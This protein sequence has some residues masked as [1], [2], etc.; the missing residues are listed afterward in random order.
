M[1]LV[2][3]WMVGW[4]WN[5][6][7]A[8]MR[9]M[10]ERGGGGDGVLFYKRTAAHRG[11]ETGGAVASGLAWAPAVSGRCGKADSAPRE[12]VDFRIWME[13]VSV[14]AGPAACLPGALSRLRFTRSRVRDSG[15]V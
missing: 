7:G 12:Q 9:G 8:V 4:S 3:T 14:I 11:A 6:A 1:S 2:G 5:G 15:I 10:M 13:G